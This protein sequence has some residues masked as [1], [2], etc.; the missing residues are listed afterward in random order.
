MAEFGSERC[1][2]AS[3]CCVPMVRTMRGE[4]IPFK[5]YPQEIHPERLWVVRHLGNANPVVDV[6]CGHNKTVPRA[7]GVD[8]K[9]VTDRM[10]SADALPFGSGTVG[11][12]IS[13]H[14][15]EHVLDP[16]KVLREWH[17]VLRPGGT[18]LIVLPDHAAVDTMQPILSAGTHLHAYTMDSFANLVGVV[19]GYKITLSEVV[20]SEWSF[21]AVLTAVNG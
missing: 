2:T 12:I 13:R 14:S 9:P 20:L 3:M 6:G 21:G 4:M 17:R 11:C 8:V 5:D 7:I 1:G 15:F 19:G 10:A 18:V 16:V